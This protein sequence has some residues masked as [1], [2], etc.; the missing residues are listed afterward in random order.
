MGNFGISPR[1]VNITTLA[2]SHPA[3]LQ[4]LR[5]QNLI[6]STTWAYTAGFFGNSYPVFGSLTL[7]GYDTTRFRGTGVSFPFGND[8]S[9]D[10]LVSI[11]GITTGSVATSGGLLPGGPI[12]AYIDS[13]VP[14]I[15]LPLDACRAFERAFNLTWSD[16]SE[17]YL[18]S[19]EQHAA[20]KRQNPT[21]TFNLGSSLAG[22]S[23]VDIVLP[24]AAFD[25]NLSAPITAPDQPPQYYFPLQRAQNLSQYVLGRT[26]LQQAYVIADY[27]RS[28]FTVA[29][30]LFPQQNVK[31]NVVSIYPP[32]SGPNGSANETT[33]MT[34]T[35]KSVSGGG[36][37]GIVIGVVALLVLI[38]L[39][40]LLWRRSVT[41]KNKKAETAKGEHESMS[42]SPGGI[43]GFAGGPA[44]GISTPTHG[45][46][47][48]YGAFEKAEL[49][50]TATGTPIA[51]PG[52]PMSNNSGGDYMQLAG[53]T[54]LPGQ[55]R[56]V[57]EAPDT[58]KAKTG[59][60]DSTPTVPR[61]EM[62]A[63]QEINEMDGD[64][65]DGGKKK[66]GDGGGG[67]SRGGRGSGPVY[68]MPG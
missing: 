28:N 11:Q 14:A 52:S 63:S 38:A 27:D 5:D 19:D 58:V 8:I 59:E 50:N 37:A 43:P 2:N 46:P 49:E 57:H 26:F 34:K 25:L 53:K 65:V 6:P 9:R 29:Q 12:N 44:P 31:P 15:W 16:Q 61:Q 48:E 55:D 3:P 36:I 20:L 4:N 18:L 35:T 42:Q 7:G 33:S 47:P 45:Q 1:I 21:V 64:S 13:T 66:E 54:E 24:Y 32:G 41:K 22:G 68:E 30:A 40:I 51:S 62:D 56:N 17:Y 23:T 10:L 67:S 60:L 39:A